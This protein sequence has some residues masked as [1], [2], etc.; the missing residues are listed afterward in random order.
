MQQDAVAEG[1]EGKTESEHS[2]WLHVDEAF[3]LWAA[4]PPRLEGLVAGG[5]RADP[6]AVDAHEWLNVPY[7]CAFAIVAPPEGYRVRWR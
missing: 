2:A 4:A 6:W 5:D 7:D 1:K 3:G